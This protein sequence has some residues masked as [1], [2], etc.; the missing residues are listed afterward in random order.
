MLCLIGHFYP[1]RV[2]PPETIHFQATPEQQQFY[3]SAY[4]PQQ[5][6]YERNARTAAQLFHIQEQLANFIAGNNLAGSHVLE[7]GSGQGSLQDLVA[8]YTGL[9]ISATARRKYHKPYVQADARAMPFKDGAFDAVWTIWVLEHVPNPEQALREMR[10]V[11]KPNG[12]LFLDPAWNCSELAPNGYHIRPFSDFGF[13]GKLIKA[14]VP[15]ESSPWFRLMY[16]LPIRGIRLAAATFAGRPIALHYRP[17]AANYN[18][19]WESDSDAVNSIDV[20]EAYLWFKSRGDQ[21]LNCPSQGT[22]LHTADM[23]LIIRVKPR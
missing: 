18:Q 17:I 2:D 22:M 7:V 21:C 20:F 11:L 6:R 3:D 5:E 23:P 15:F 16:L 13:G 8:D 10:R 1:S 19:Y 4:D 12:L 14:T 9:D